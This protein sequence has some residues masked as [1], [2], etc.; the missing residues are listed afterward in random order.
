MRETFKRYAEMTMAG[1][2]L[3]CC[4][5]TLKP[6]WVGENS[7]KINATKMIAD[8]R[9]GWNLTKNL[10]FGPF[11]TDTFTYGFIE[12][13][14]DD[15]RGSHLAPGMESLAVSFTIVK[16]NYAFKQYDSAGNVVKVT[17]TAHRNIKR[18]GFE[19]KR[20]DPI[21]LDNLCEI[22]I[23]SGVAEQTIVY[24]QHMAASM[25][26]GKDSIMVTNELRR[27]NHHRIFQGVVFKLRNETIAAV[28][29][30][31]KGIVWIKND[32]TNYQKLHVAAIATAILLA[33]NLDNEN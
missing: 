8:G 1:L 30:T 21:V 4:C 11:H 28:D 3:L 16:E 32:L 29:L 20:S 33:P 23:N 15:F 25:Q 13:T 2:L 14:V 24:S 18:S 6:D 31:K 5:A 26:I 17:C 7:F 9:Y 12:K 27:D 22:K 10:R 19:E